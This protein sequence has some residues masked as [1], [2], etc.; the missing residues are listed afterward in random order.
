MY[1]FYLDFTTLYMYIAQLD[2]LNQSSEVQLVEISLSSELSMFLAYLFKF[3]IFH[4][5]GLLLCWACTFSFRR[6]ARR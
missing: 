4:G 3:F 6:T 2:N 1:N 5:S